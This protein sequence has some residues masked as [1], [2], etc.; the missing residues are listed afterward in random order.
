ML[1]VRNAIAEVLDNTSLSDMQAAG[2]VDSINTDLV[3]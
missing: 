3:A 2:G 1:S